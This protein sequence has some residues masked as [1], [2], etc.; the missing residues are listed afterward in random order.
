M[1][2]W[3]DMTGAQTNLVT[4]EI[5]RE[6][7]EGRYAGWGS[8]PLGHVADSPPPLTPPCHL[9]IIY[10]HLSV[11]SF[12]IVPELRPSYSLTLVTLDVTESC[13]IQFPQRYYLSPLI[14]IAIPF[15]RVIIFLFTQSYKRLY[16]LFYKSNIIYFIQNPMS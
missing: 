7:D 5:Y 14:V 16:V 12:G 9:F 6:K 10:V 4:L 3:S 15:R 2:R 1:I 8:A 11:I 13:F